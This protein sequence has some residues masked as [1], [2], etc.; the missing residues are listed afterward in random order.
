MWR[1][2]GVSVASPCE[3][4]ADAAPIVNRRTGAV[5][6]TDVTI[7]ADRATRRRGLLGRD[8]L[9]ANEA[10]V[11]VPC[12]AIHTWRMRFPID[13]LFVDRAGRVIGAR[14]R[15][16]PGRMAAAFGA[17]AVI[18]LADGRIAATGTRAGDE[19]GRF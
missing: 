18:E 10:L 13:V 12:F 7:A 15:M 6:A 2:H 3:E 14:R 5:L 8:C 17:H 1:R 4:P 11:L 9:S 16:P 19:L